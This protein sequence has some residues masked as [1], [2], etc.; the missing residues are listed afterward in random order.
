[1]HNY[2]LR[3]SAH[4]YKYVELI[5]LII[6]TFGKTFEKKVIFLKKSFSDI[7]KFPLSKVM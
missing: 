7:L 3:T 1:M 4:N 5:Q 6:S 2:K